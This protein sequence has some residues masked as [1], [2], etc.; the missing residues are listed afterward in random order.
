MTNPLIQEVINE[1]GK[2][3]YKLTTFDIEV[4]AKMN[5][6]LAPTIVYLHNDK[7]VTDWIRAI[8]FNPKQPS[9]YIEDYDRFQAMLFH[10]EEKAIND[11]YDTISIRPKNMSTGKQILWSCAV[12]AL[13][14]IPL[15]VAIFLM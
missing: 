5:G 12:L 2:T 10:K 4:I 14:S 13:M 15:L 1:D 6:G 7:D 11:L 3:V 8:R 9:S